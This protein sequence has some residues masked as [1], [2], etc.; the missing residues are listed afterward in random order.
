M[1]V[2]CEGQE[3]PEDYLTFIAKTSEENEEQETYE[4]MTADEPLD[5]YEDPGTVGPPEKMGHHCLF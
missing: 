1:Y 5:L 2:E 4:A 3:Q